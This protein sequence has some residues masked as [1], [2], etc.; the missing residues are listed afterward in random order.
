MIIMDSVLCSIQHPF[1][2][3]INWDDLLN[4]RIEP[5]LKPQLVRTA[6][7]TGRNVAHV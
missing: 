7:Q 3:G 4:R 6:C 1:F 2:A 5:P